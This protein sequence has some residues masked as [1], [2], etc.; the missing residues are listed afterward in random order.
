[1]IPTATHESRT[2]LLLQYRPITL[3]RR[4]VSISSNH[5]FANHLELRNTHSPETPPD[6]GYDD[7]PETAWRFST[8]ASL[9][10]GRRV[11]SRVAHEQLLQQLL[12]RLQQ[13]PH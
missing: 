7:R 5:L 12:E 4:R 2:L 3:T 10:V 8:T 9:P 11:R 13:L 1:M 6:N